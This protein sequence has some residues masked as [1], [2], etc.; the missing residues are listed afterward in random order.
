[1]K[2]VLSF[3]CL[4][5]CAYYAIRTVPSE[6][7]G[8]NVCHAQS[9]QG[10]EV[11]ARVPPAPLLPALSDGLAEQ[12][13]ERTAYTVSYNVD[14]RQ[15]NWVAW[16]I[17]RQ[18]VS[19]RNMVVDRPSNA[20]FH[21]DEQVPRPRATLDDYRGSGWT[22]GHM[23]PAGDCR[24][25][26]DVQ[27]ESFLLT[28]V[29]PQSRYLNS[30]VWNDIEKSCR[31]WALRYGKVYVV[32]GPI[33]FKKSEKGSIGRN[34]VTVPDAFFKVILCLDSARPKAIGFVCRNEKEAA[35]QTGYVKNGKKRPKRELYVHSVD[36]VERI[37]GY[38][39]FPSLP[40]DIESE[41]EARADPDEW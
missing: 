33:F 8:G 40:D 24:W 16:V 14:T 10:A 17:T 39:F 22:R 18:N 23:C 6:L 2:K 34:R 21:E 37:T 11:A 5:L 26:G 19:E 27:Y 29:S 32:A 7:A 25:R 38:D 4:A 13:L 28:N 12:L 9:S 41:V 36:E 31:R 30:G 20:P 35:A 1:M 15:P 3:L